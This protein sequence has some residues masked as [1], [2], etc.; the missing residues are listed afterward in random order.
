[1][2]DAPGSPARRGGHGGRRVAVIGRIWKS[3]PPPRPWGPA[4]CQAAQQ[5]ARTCTALPEG[6]GTVN[7][8]QLPGGCRQRKA[9]VLSAPTGRV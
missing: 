2:K 9:A 6:Q 5:E 8:K 4:I 1:M 3:P 7:S